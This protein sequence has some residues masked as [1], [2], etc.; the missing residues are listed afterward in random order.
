MTETKNFEEI[1]K[2]LRHI[3]CQIEKYSSRTLNKY[4]ISYAS[5][6][7]LIIIAKSESITLGQLSK[8][9]NISLPNCS[10]ICSRLEKLGLIK[11][12]KG[13]DDQRFLSISLTDRAMEVI[14]NVEKEM[15]EFHMRAMKRLTE[16]ERNIICQ[17]LEL[18]DKALKDEED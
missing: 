5:A 11:R 17:G 14:G 2:T 8:A 9:A 13:E 6:S 10:S 1:I 7:I 3:K 4:G 12:D 16:E 18:M 15:L